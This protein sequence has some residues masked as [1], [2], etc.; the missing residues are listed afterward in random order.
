[1]AHLELFIAWLKDAHGM[2][3][4]LVPVLENHAKDA[5]DYPEIQARIQQH[6]Q[7]TQ[8]HAK[9]L[10]QLLQQQD[11]APSKVKSVLGGLPGMMQG[12]A[13]FPLEDQIVKNALSDFAAENFEIACYSALIVVAKE[14]GYT[15]AQ[16]VC[17]EILDQELEMARWLHD[18]LPT[19][20]LETLRIKQAEHEMTRSV[21]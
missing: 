19:A 16:S 6:A 12:V 18:Q 20:A 4:A 21:V 11:K 7:E 17:E 10:E 8:I 1:M 13:T 5:K 9:R 15:Q 3:V 14:L 2:E